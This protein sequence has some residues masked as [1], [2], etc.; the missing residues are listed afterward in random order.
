M[1]VN[2]KE[3]EAYHRM[4]A[5][6]GLKEEIMHTASNRKLLLNH[7]KVPKALGFAICVLLCFGC[8]ISIQHHSSNVG[9]YYEGKQVQETP[10]QVSD[11]IMQFGFKRERD[12][13]HVELTIETKESTKVSVLEGILQCY[14]SNGTLLDVGDQ[15]QIEG[16]KIIFWE[17]P[18]P[19]E[20]MQL[21]VKNKNSTQSFEL[22]FSNESQKWMLQK[23]VNDINGGN[24]NEKNVINV[25]SCNDVL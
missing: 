18:N 6:L 22:Y 23:E 5:P 7:R 12:V 19:S 1:I 13:F 2:K 9:V 14:D 17:I 4:R 24:E 15:I 11:G 8:F 3:V 21:I 16:K 20:S 10:I 25:T